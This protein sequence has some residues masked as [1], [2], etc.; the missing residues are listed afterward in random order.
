M[1]ES[2]P[3]M[4][5]SDPEMDQSDPEMDQSD[6]EMDE[7]GPEMDQFEGLSDPEIARDGCDPESRSIMT[8]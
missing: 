5:Q 4:D 6:P 8:Q 2:D 3:E 7:S 1:D